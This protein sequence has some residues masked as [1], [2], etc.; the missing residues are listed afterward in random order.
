[1]VVRGSVPTFHMKQI[2]QGALR[3]LE[4]VCRIDNQIEVTRS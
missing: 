3:E 2:V 1:L 4:S